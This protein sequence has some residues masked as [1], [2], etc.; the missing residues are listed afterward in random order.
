MNRRWT[1][2]RFSL[3]SVH[4]HTGV[5]LCIEPASSGS[6]SGVLPSSSSCIYTCIVVTKASR[7]FRNS[8]S[9]SLSLAKFRPNRPCNFNSALSPR[10]CC[11]VI[12]SINAVLSRCACVLVYATLAHRAHMPER[13]GT[14]FYMYTARCVSAS[15]RLKRGDDRTHPCARDFQEGLIFGA[16][17]RGCDV[18]NMM[19][20]NIRR[21]RDK[22]EMNW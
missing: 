12:W 18:Y 13:C 20:E 8:S 17:S 15:F 2:D 4:T 5:E 22:G 9:P 6:S 7:H 1:L 11:S 10:Y 3:N 21:E 14:R 19:E 16:K